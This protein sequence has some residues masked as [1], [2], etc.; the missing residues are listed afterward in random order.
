MTNGLNLQVPFLEALRAAKTPLAV[1]LVNGI[2]LTGYVESFD[3][4]VILLQNSV[5]QMVYKH[6]ISTIKAQEDEQRYVNEAQ[7]YSR[8]VV[9]IAEGHAKRV[10]SLRKSAHVA[11]RY[12]K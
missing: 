3:D 6:A 7:A 2:K 10:I 12:L 8:G 4:H 11:Q 1:Y 5:G 9:P